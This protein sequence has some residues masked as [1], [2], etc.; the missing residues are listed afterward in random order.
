MIATITESNQI[1]A[2]AEASQVISEGYWEWGIVGQRAG[3]NGE[4]QPG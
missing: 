3:H 4:M 2:G 1:F